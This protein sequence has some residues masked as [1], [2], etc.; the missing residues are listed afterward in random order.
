MN[1]LL[2]WGGHPAVHRLGWTLLHFLWQGAVVAALFAAAQTAW[3]KPSSNARYWTGCL[4]LGADGG[5]LLERIRRITG[6]P[7]DGNIPSRRWAG[8][9]WVVALVAVIF[10]SLLHQPSS[11]SKSSG[12]T[13]EIRCT[14]TGLKAGDEIP[15]EFV[16]KNNGPW[17]Y[18]YQD[19]TYDRSGRMDEYKL[20]AKTASGRSVPNPRL[21]FDYMGGPYNNSVLH[22]GESFSKIIP[23]NLWALV[24]EPGRYEVTGAYFEDPFAEKTA[25]RHIAKPIHIN[26]L[27]RTKEEMTDY[28]R[29]L[30]NQVEAQM[31]ISAGRPRGW[32]DF[33]DD[34]DDL[35]QKLRFTCSPEIVPVLLRALYA[36]GTET[37][38]NGTQMFDN[39]SGF[40]IQEALLHY[41]PHSAVTGQAILQ[42]ATRQGLN[43]S[44]VFLLRG[45]KFNQ[46]EL[47]PVIERA[48]AGR[49]TV[50]WQMAAEVAAGSRGVTLSA[51]SG[52]LGIVRSLADESFYDSAFTAPL[53]A[54]A[55]NTNALLD[56][57]IAAI[58]AL[59]FNRTDAGVK[60]LKT[61]LADPDPKTSKLAEDAIRAAY[62]NRRA[63]GKPLRADDF[64]AKF[65]QPEAPPS[66]NPGAT[67]QDGARPS[68][69][70]NRAIP[71]VNT[72]A[73]NNTNPTTS[74]SSTS[75]T[76]STT[77]VKTSAPGNSNPGAS[78]PAATN[79][80]NAAPELI[81]LPSALSLEIRCTNTGLK[82]GDKISIQFV[83]SNHGTEDF[84]HT[85]FEDF[86]HRFSKCRLSAKT[87]SGVSV[88][89]PRV[90]YRGPLIVS[91]MGME[92]VLQPGQS[93]TNSHPLNYWTLINEPGRY[94]V[95]GAYVLDETTN[96]IV[97]V[98]SAPISIVVLP[99]TKEEMHD[100]VTGLTNQIAAR[101]PLPL[102][103]GG[104]R[105]D[106]VLND[107]LENLM[108]TCSPVMI[109]T[110]LA[111]IQKAA[112]G[113]E[114]FLAVEGLL[115][116][117]PRSDETRKAIADAASKPD[118]N[119]YL[120]SL[121][122]QYDANIDAKKPPATP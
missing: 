81:T 13:L 62:N 24:K 46:G 50:E 122:K 105:Y 28:I 59:A 70:S 64:D 6:A 95:T 48:L 87:A 120:Q 72:A 68:S 4:A 27:P 11:A 37:D 60:T 115:N 44:M 89:D 43:W 1:P 47:K 77:V 104:Y 76:P 98:K 79:Q 57:R 41:V 23:L 5:S 20:A 21:L 75:S 52:E 2:Q 8:G 82:V 121:L 65:Q 9:A 101:L 113:N 56:A 97:S 49:N 73:P 118:A 74:T 83:I 30:S 38:T 12:L 91:V 109:P 103:R 45:Y 106:P 16:I 67:S 85:E 92:Q 32:P 66:T 108:Y 80:T 110:M 14:N 25:G 117:T 88:P 61:I 102:N 22:P 119:S 17:D 112:S 86:V 58:V 7:V 99:R 69:G 29:G 111:T 33:N 94:E 54:V 26:I 107:L 63:P 78:P 15:V 39:N 53:I 35:L 90:R 100:Y 116:Y 40:Q 84:K 51:R 55:F 34:L 31:V 3:R 114:I 18:K 71:A 93:F 10:I 42:A 36:D 19:R 96:S